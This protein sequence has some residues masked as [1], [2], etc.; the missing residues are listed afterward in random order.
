M[1]CVLCMKRRVMICDDNGKPI[2]SALTTQCVGG[3]VKAVEINVYDER[4][5]IVFTGFEDVLEPF[6][7]VITLSIVEKEE[8]E[9]TRV[10]PNGT[11]VDRKEKYNAC[12]I[13]SVEFNGC[14]VF[15][16]D[17]HVRLLKRD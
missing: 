15:D 17:D 14:K 8:Y 10:F 7:D 4:N 11:S 9:Y 13:K 5:E 16:I 2:R 6:E 1:E 12:Y 3:E